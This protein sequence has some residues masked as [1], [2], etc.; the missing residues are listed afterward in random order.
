[1]AEPTCPVCGRAFE[2]PELHAVLSR[3]LTG[4]PL[5]S[6]AHARWPWEAW[7]GAMPTAKRRLVAEMLAIDTSALS[8]REVAV[9]FRTIVRTTLR[10][11]TAAM[12]RGESLPPRVSA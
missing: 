3:W 10:F 2:S 8:D 9:R 11:M 7:D 5:C 1:M 12:R 6:A 4:A